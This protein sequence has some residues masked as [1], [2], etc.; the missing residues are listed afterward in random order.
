MD[1]ERISEAFRS[2]LEGKGLKQNGL[3]LQS[4][5]PIFLGYNRDVQFKE[6]DRSD[7]GDMLLFQY[8]THDWGEGQ[9]FEVDFTRQF[10]EVFAE[11]DGHEIHQQSIT[12]FFD[13]VGF[14]DIERF[15]TWSTEHDDFTGFENTI[16]N[17][18]GFAA[19]LT[20]SP[21]KQSV[22]VEHVC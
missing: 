22:T 20:K 4:F 16:R 6:V 2:Y 11:R 15:N 3:S 18:L 9:F 8:G 12:F 21:V 5:L 14:E 19:A 1:R 17:S 10:Y 13:P 7:D